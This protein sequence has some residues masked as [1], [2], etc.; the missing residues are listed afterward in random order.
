[1]RRDVGRGALSRLKTRLLP[2]AAL[3]AV[4]VALALATDRFLTLANLWS[5]FEVL[6][7]AYAG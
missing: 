6:R 4:S 3:L 5:L 7:P 1:M 2:F